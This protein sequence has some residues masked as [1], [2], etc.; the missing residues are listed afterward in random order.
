M[1]YKRH[2]TTNRK[3]VHAADGVN[4]NTD[5]GQEIQEEIRQIP[6]PNEVDSLP[7]PPRKALDKHRP[8]FLDAFKNRIQ[9]DDI[10]LLGLLFLLLD[11][12]LEDDLLLIILVYIF[13]TGMQ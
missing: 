11:E 1:L 8:S 5:M 2:P 9:L 10:I 3:Y 7:P 6:M 12:S 13:L 4:L